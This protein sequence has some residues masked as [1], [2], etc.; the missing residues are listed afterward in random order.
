MAEIHRFNHRAMATYFEVR[1]ADVERGY[2]AQ[3]AQAAL[4][5]LD[6]LE[7]R[8]SRFRANSEIAQIARLAPGECL[9]LNEST[10]ACLEVTKKMELATRGAFSPAPAALQS[11]NSL[12]RWSLLPEEQSI[13]CESGRLEFDLGAIGKGLALDRMAELLREWDC[14]SFLLVAG[15]SSILAGDPPNDAPGW[16]CGLGDDHAPHRFFLRHASLSGSGL[17]VKG[18]H[19]LDPRTGSPAMRQSRAWALTDVAAESD[20]LSTASMVLTESELE[21]V[22]VQDLSWLVLFQAGESIRTQGSRALPP[23]AYL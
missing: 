14:H 4:D 6:K 12:P 1:I 20:A 16:S 21:D 5:L 8:L 9:R 15:R 2:A 7:S 3:A 22:L 11:Q 17:A 23:K 19:I 10:F 18:N 13:R